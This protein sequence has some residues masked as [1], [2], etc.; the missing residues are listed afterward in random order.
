MPLLIRG[1]LKLASKYE[2][3]SLRSQIV[4]H[5]EEDWPTTPLA[6]LRLCNDERLY[7]EDYTRYVTLKEGEYIEDKFP[8]PA[9]AIRLARDFDIP[10]ILPAA[11]LK[12]LYADPTLD[13]DDIRKTKDG[14]HGRLA[15]SARWTL[16]DRLDMLRLAQGRAR[17]VT[18]LPLVHRAFM[19]PQVC[20]VEDDSDYDT[21]DEDSSNSAQGC[22]QIIIQKHKEFTG[23]RYTSFWTGVEEAGKPDPIRVLQKLRDGAGDWKLCTFCTDAFRS[24]ISDEIKR[25]W[26]DLPRIFGLAPA[27][28]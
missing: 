17:L 2:V 20:R 1:I 18:S 11:Y 23:S 24:R 21:G 16:L 12:L 22:H 26:D 7:M 9:S 28:T 13:W 8:E 27:E 14:S 3:D 25:H 6:W 5:L 4:Q 19:V 15:R 10:S